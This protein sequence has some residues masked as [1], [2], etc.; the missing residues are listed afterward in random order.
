MEPTKFEYFDVTADIGVRTWG[1]TI[2]EIFENAA[3]AVTSL[4]MN[5]KLIEKKIARDIEVHGNDLSSLLINWITEL[6]IIRDSEG[7]L[8]STFEVNISEDHKSLKTKA[9]GDIIV[10]INYE[11]DIKAITYSL[12]RLEKIDNNFFLQ[13]VL[14]I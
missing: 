13:F 5:P 1:M 2:N 3:L 4:I 6:L 12:F 7:L 10:G 11:M 14:D 8:F 9:W